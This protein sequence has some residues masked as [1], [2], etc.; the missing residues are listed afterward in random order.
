M[1]SEE[2]KAITT[3]EPTIDELEEDLERQFQALNSN[4]SHP[5]VQLLESLTK[6]SKSADYRTPAEHD[7]IINLDLDDYGSLKTNPP[8][9]TYYN[10]LLARHDNNLLNQRDKERAKQNKRHVR[11]RIFKEI[12]GAT[13]V[14]VLVLGLPAYLAAYITSSIYEEDAPSIDQCIGEFSVT[15]NKKKPK[16]VEKIW[17]QVDKDPKVTYGT[18]TR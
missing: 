7:P 6:D 2:N 4:N 9:A 18:I 15:P 17:I 3:F 12:M 8:S 13:I 5:V 10:S 1:F 11:W 14:I 16:T